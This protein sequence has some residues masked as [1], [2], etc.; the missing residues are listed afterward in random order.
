LSPIAIEKIEIL[1]AVL[2]LP[3]KQ[4]YQSSPFT[5]KM[6]QMGRISSAV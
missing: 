5:K 6:S 1:G 2:E 3:A 4:H